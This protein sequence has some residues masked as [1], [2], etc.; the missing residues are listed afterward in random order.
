MTYAAPWSRT[1]T[2]ITS[3]IVVLMVGIGLVMPHPLLSVAAWSSIPLFAAF[4]VRGYAIEGGELV[5]RFPLHTK[6]IALRGLEGAYHDPTAMARS[7]RV[8]GNGGVF[9]FT[10]HFRNASLGGYR[11][12]V[13]DP[14][15]AVVLHLP[16]QVVVVSPDRPNLFLEE[17]TSRVGIRDRGPGGHAEPGSTPEPDRDGSGPRPGP[18]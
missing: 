9:G 14:E 15:R 6:R 12:W 18:A 5:I 3:G 13:T 4:A 7:L 11:A 10:G 2:L 16:D 8:F 17:L 1:V